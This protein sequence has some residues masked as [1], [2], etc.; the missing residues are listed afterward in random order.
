ML[1][2]TTAF[3]SKCW[4]G[5]SPILYALVH[6]SLRTIICCS[7]VCFVAR[8]K[9][10]LLLKGLFLAHST[11]SSTI[12]T[13]QPSAW[14]TNALSEE[15]IFHSRN[16]ACAVPSKSTLW[17][18]LCFNRYLEKYFRN[19][20][21]FVHSIFYIIKILHEKKAKFEILSSHYS[22]LKWLIHSSGWP[23]DVVLQWLQC[24]ANC[25][26]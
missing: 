22:P 7:S 1:G 26:G 21:C 5:Y 8:D 19:W 11:L 12:H 14:E 16:F 3:H 23:S 25:C 10:Q 18:R 24:L 17:S 20:K 2:H 4:K 6:H 15:T 9:S 13:F